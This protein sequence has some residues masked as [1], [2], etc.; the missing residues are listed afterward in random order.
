MAKKNK[1]NYFDA[2][3]DQVTVAAEEADLLIE[4][5]ESFTS[6]EDLKSLLERAHEIEHRGD[7]INHMIRT[8]VSTDFITPIDREDIVEL[9]QRLDDVTDNIEGILQRFYMFDIHFMH[10]R[11]MEF[12]VIIK[13]S[14]KALSKS[15]DSFRE[16]K[17]VKKIRAMVQDVNDLEEQA[18]E[19]Y[20]EVIRQLYTDDAEKAE[21]AVR[22]EVW[23]RLFDRLEGTIDSCKEVA[24]TVATIML[25]NV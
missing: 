22:V 8:Y 16:F 5:I 18:D 19:L 7:E 12:A 24:D 3:Q 25:K 1:F 2:F 4:A 15:M 13:K 20:M 9:A 21:N 17:K 23:S 10:N 11:T 6:A 14:L